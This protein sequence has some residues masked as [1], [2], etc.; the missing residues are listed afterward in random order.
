MRILI[1]LFDTSGI[2]KLARE[3]QELDWKIL[4]SQETH[5]ILSKAG[6]PSTRI[7]QFTAM[8]EDFGFPPTLHPKIEASLTS[9]TSDSIIDIVFDIPYPLTKGNDVGGYALL[10]L[11]AKGGRIPVMSKSDMQSV[12]Q[13]VKELGKVSIE[14][15]SKLISKVHTVISGHYLNIL[16]QNGHAGD[17]LIGKHSQT[18]LNGENPY[19]VSC[20]LFD[21]IDN[22]D[23]LALS[24]FEQLSGEAPCFTNF[25]DL[26]SILHSMCIAC[27]AFNRKF[28]SRPFMV[29]ASKHGNPCGFSVDW[30]VPDVALKKALWGN[31]LAIWGGEL[32]CNFHVNDDMGEMFLE[33]R[34]RK[35]KLGN[36]RWMLDVIAA[37]SFSEGAVKSLGK[38]KNRKIFKNEQLEQ[39]FIKNDPWDFRSV[40]GGFLT[41]SPLNYVLDFG[42]IEFADEQT[43]RNHLSSVILSWASAW[44]SNLGGNEVAL[45]K[46]LQLIGLGG[47]PATTIAADT[48]LKRAQES[49]HDT[50]SSIF[51]AD[52]F[53]PFTD[54]PEILAKAGCKWG[55]VPKGGIREEEVRDYFKDQGI[56]VYYLPEQ[57]RG[58]CRH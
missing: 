22:G 25:A 1:S 54:A 44:S 28:S 27:E 47:G 17:G 4:C 34:E 45:V 55:L 12:L 49:G 50:R 14:L 11:A 37:P 9:T 10:A 39:P 2:E 20:N 35:Q 56:K 30:K 48:A 13:E 21:N 3:F 33:D 41:Q 52:A 36:G 7:E 58:F 24:R 40:R 6:I 32:I 8:Q 46:D 16:R 53:F 31:P 29:I 43:D 18:L 51:A 5:S 19:Q 23:L 38:Q 57:F 42:N 15:K 26:D